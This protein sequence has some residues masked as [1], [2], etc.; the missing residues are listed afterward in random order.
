MKEIPSQTPLSTQIS[1]I[2]IKRG[3]TFVGPTIVYAFMQAS[4]FV[5]DHLTSCFRHGHLS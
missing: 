2:L 1:K 3:F 4:G 5:N